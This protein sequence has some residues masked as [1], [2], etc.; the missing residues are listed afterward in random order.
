M[1]EFIYSIAG[2]ILA[3]GILV[4]VH[5]FGH[6]WV[7]RRLGIKVLKFSV[8]FGRPIWSRTASDGTVY[9]LGSLPLGGYVKMLDESE[10][11]VA[12]ED[13]HVAFNRQ[14]IWK[15]TLVVL[16]GPMFNFLFAIAAYSLVFAGGIEGLSPVVGKVVE[17]SV[18]QK[19]G[20]RSGDLLLSVDGRK[21]SIWQEQRL[22]LFSKA[23]ARKTVQ[24]DIQTSDGRKVTR[25]LNL[26]DV[27]MSK[28][29][30]RL[31]ARG[32]GLI[33]WYPTVPPVIDQVVNGKPAFNSGLKHGDLI[34]AIDG[35]KTGSWDDVVRLISAS[36]GRQ[37]KLDISRN[38]NPESV[39]VT[40]EKA[41]DGDREVG[42]IGI[43]VQPVAIPEDRKVMVSYGLLESLYKGTE[44][45]WMMSVLTLRM[46]VKMVTLEI[47]SKNISGPI[48]IAQYAGK[49]AQVGF[50]SFILF[51]AIVSVSLG[52]LNLLPVPLLDGGHLLYYSIEAVTR[53]PVPE[54]VM[55]LGQQVGILLLF[56]LMSLAVYNDLGRLFP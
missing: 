14:P 45:T 41:M 15:R 13:K 36:P 8:G 33:A 28:I 10:G 48:T 38:G 42:R 29:D 47:S 21:L 32:I 17:G 3:L 4:T 19:D 53:K 20:F 46:L 25:S 1:L 43:S 39:F 22:Y 27:P 18:A 31:V 26:A 12:E 35:E 24:Y 50:S 49:S 7:A 54:K 52:V 11:E 23:L 51:L 44:T 9:A 16:A 5:E 37:L 55:I 40:P 34:T 56:L 30:A 6:F 2:F